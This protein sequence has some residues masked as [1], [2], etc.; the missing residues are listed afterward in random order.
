MNRR[1]ILVILALC[2][3]LMLYGCAN[4]SK[5]AQWGAVCTVYLDNLPKEYNLLPLELRE[6]T[7]ITFS[8]SNIS[9]DRVYRIA[10]TEKNG[11]RQEVDMLPGNYSVSEVYVSNH[12]I[13]PLS[14]AAQAEN[15]LLEQNHETHLAVS[16]ADPSALAQTI[17]LNTPT[18]E[19][20]QAAPYSRQVQYAGTVL[21]LNSIPQ[22]MSFPDIQDKRLS[23]GETYEIP[24]SS[25][26]GVCLIV[27]NTTT[28]IIPL[29]EATFVGVKFTNNNAVFPGGLTIGSA[30]KDVANAR[31]G[32]LGTPS[33]C[34][35]S[36]LIGFS[37]NRSALVYLDH[38]LG[39]RLSLTI[40][41]SSSVVTSI[42]YEFDVYQ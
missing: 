13:M 16:L 27:K 2:C 6:K 20:L 40:D 7:T 17:Q 33:Y 23:S 19:I 32:L 42:S 21:N 28:S 25:H 5:D 10:L 3:S 26:S 34:T 37:L 1:F 14:A 22:V 31:S 8:I 15:I 30:L 39:D 11:Y 18:P 24:S 12:S 41:S 35:G 38:A 29:N 9:L 36:P 4:H